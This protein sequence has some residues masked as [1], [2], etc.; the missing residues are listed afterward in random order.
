MSALQWGG[1]FEGS[2][3]ASLLSF[4]SSLEDDLVLA[5]FD[6]QCSLAH[7]SALEGGGIVTRESARDLRA[8]LATVSK[9]IERGEFFAWA[10]ASG[11][12]DV[13]GAI[14]ARVRELSG[15]N[16]ERLHAGRS[17]NDQ[18]AT[19]LALYARDRARRGGAIARAIARELLSKA[20]AE[21]DAGTTIAATTHWQPAQPALLAFWLVAACE[22]FARAVRRAAVAEEAATT[23]CPLGSGAVA[24]ST[25]PLDRTAAA[26]ELGFRAPSRNAMDAIGTRDALL[27]V[28]HAISR[29][30]VDASRVAS[31]LVVWCAPAFAYA[32]LGDASSTG[33][34]LMPQK[35]NPDPYELV[36]AAAAE[37]FG[38]YASAVDVLR[39]LP[40]SYHRDL[41][42]CKRLAIRA[43]ETGLVALRA[44]SSALADTQF[45]RAATNARAADGF[46]VATDVADALIRAGVSSR[47]AH[48]LV[49]LAVSKAEREGRPLE[50][51]DLVEIA[52]AA[53]V[54]ALDVALDAPSSVRAKRTAGS[55]HPSEVA[56]AIAALDEELA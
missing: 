53:G 10:R 4:G 38:S 13:H 36:R 9:E 27:D 1:R 6:V 51:R 44:F 31:E 21:L 47:R 50:T 22:P 37:S 28:A 8:A 41:Q 46:T 29:A 20:K 15:E 12:E 52:G 3:D 42:T 24:G 49:G 18:V 34:S 16:G 14:D 2:P 40:L 25:L 30:L 23:F 33:S 55:T 32:R 17:R 35:R 45:Q 39:G 56:A 7:V 54:K 43:I 11:A 5:P 48:E 19:T 26:S